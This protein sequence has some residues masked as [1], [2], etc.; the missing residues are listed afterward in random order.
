MPEDEAKDETELDGEDTEQKEEDDGLEEDAE[1]DPEL[2]EAAES[3]GLD[4]DA[5]ET[6]RE[7]QR[8]TQTRILKLE[9]DLA[10]APAVEKEDE[11]VLAEIGVQLRGKENE[12]L[13]QNLVKNIE[14]LA[15]T[16]KDNFDKLAKR[17]NAPR[18]GDKE[19]RQTVQQ[20]T[21]AIRNL[22]AQNVQFRLDRWINKTPKL[23]TY[24][25]DGDS[26]ELD[27]DGKF[28]RRRR[29][30]IRRAD[31]IATGRKGDF[32]ME[33]MFAK[34]FKKMVPKSSATDKKTTESKSTRMARASGS[35][36]K[37]QVDTSQSEASLKAEAAAVVRKFQ[38]NAR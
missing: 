32:V 37:D 8:E 26:G 25:G 34:A 13:D 5:F 16:T 9:A 18:T 27:Q 11:L 14:G 36:G 35:S 7:L 20:L 15:T 12:D 10:K 24:L 29:S 17:I 31:K 2:I 22:S 4:P 19:L 33:N 21:S 38:R 28:A 1:F 30:L 23:Q 6:E 3:V